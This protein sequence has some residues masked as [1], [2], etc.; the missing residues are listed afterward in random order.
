MNSD[1]LHAEIV[2]PHASAVPLPDVASGIALHQ[3]APDKEGHN[4]HYGQ[5]GGV[6]DMVVVQ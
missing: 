4:D 3:F 2:R 1:V 5:R 6:I